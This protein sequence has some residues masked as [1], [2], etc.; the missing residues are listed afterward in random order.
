[1]QQPPPVA[2][3]GDV[4]DAGLAAVPGDRRGR[5]P[6]PPRRMAPVVAGCRPSI[7]VDEL[8]LAVALDAGDPDHLAPVDLEARCR[9][10]SRRSPRPA[11][12]T[13]STSS[14]TSSV[15]VDS[16][17]S[18]VGSSLP[19]ISSA[20]SPAVTSFGSHGGDG[21][22]GPQ[23]T[24]MASAIESTSSSLWE[25]NRM[26]SPWALSSRR[27]AKS[28]STSCGHEHGGGLVEDQ[29]AGPPVEDLEDLDPLALAD[30]EGLDRSGRG[31]RRGRRPSESSWMRSRASLKSMRPAGRARRRARRSRAP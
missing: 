4:A 23:D 3:L 28:S 2:V 11:T 17:V 8:G 12:E 9:S 24:V 25:M 1:M 7:D 10:S 14:S 26:V 5:G 21:P 15:T 31:R 13:S 27:L 29:D 20:R 16:R 19:T 6:R 18:G 30:P 22:A